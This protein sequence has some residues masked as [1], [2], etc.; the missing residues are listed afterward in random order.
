MA[1]HFTSESCFHSADT[2]SIQPSEPQVGYAEFPLKSDPVYLPFKTQHRIVVAI[3]RLLEECCLEWGN[4][5]VPELMKAH[6]WNEVESIELTEWTKIVLAQAKILPAAAMKRPSQQETMNNLLSVSRIRHSAVHRIRL[7]ATELLSMIS[8]AVDFAK[9]LESHSRAQKIVSLRAGLKTSLANIT[10]HRKL[11]EP[12]FSTRMELIAL[13]RAALIAQENSIIKDAIDMDRNQRAEAGSHLE[14][15]LTAWQQ[16]PVP[17]ASNRKRSW[18]EANEEFT[19]DRID[20]H[21]R[22]TQY[23]SRLYSILDYFLTSSASYMGDLSSYIG[24][25]AGMALYNPDHLERQKRVE[26]FTS[27]HSSTPQNDAEVTN[28]GSREAVQSIVRTSSNLDALLQKS[29]EEDFAK[30]ACSADSTEHANGSER[31]SHAADAPPLS[32]DESLRRQNMLEDKPRAVDMQCPPVMLKNPLHSITSTS[33]ATTDDGPKIDV[34]MPFMSSITLTPNT[35]NL[36]TAPPK[37]NAVHP[38]SSAGFPQGIGASELKLPPRPPPTYCHYR[39]SRCSS[40]D[41][42]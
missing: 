26:D 29:C 21:S 42:E 19:G 28:R 30:E 34:E 6:D 8:A 41:S 5:Y 25:K 22:G 23:A 18:D 31:P 12:Q 2:L 13:K 40:S 3:Q 7:N 24:E 9:A 16:H 14:G 27:R 39:E 32:S 35:K 20:V 11:L 10:E 17:Q 15:W 37:G 4:A 38:T 33:N 1:S 36:V